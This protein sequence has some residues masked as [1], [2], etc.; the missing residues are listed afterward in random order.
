M[1]PKQRLQCF[2][3][4]IVTRMGGASMAGSAEPAHP[5]A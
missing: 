3:P 1:G 2:V 5:A 4:R